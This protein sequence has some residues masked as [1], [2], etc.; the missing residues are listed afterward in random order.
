MWNILASFALAALAIALAIMGS[1]FW[2]IYKLDVTERLLQ[3]SL[4][5]DPNNPRHL[6]RI[7]LWW[8]HKAARCRGDEQTVAATTSLNYHERWLSCAAKSD[9]DHDYSHIKYIA[10][11]AV[12]AGEYDKATM[13]ANRL[14]D[15]AA[16]HPE[17]PFGNSLHWAHTILGFVAI[18]HGD[19][20]AANEHLRQSAE[21]PS[22]PQLASLGPSMWLTDELVKQGETKAVAAYIVACRRFVDCDDE[23]GPLG[24]WAATNRLRDLERWQRAAEAGQSPDFGRSVR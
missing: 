7:A 23:C 24:R 19:V 13:Y 14:L 9:W 17:K 16:S 5:T 22:S 2:P 3:R 20:N 6:A 1:F 4:A 12:L 8:Q 11:M 10:R 18:R 15:I 21:G